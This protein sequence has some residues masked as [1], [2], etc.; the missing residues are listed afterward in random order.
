MMNWDMAAIFWQK[1]AP[2]LAEVGSE[3][4]YEISD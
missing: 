2:K 4:G 1:K 3:V